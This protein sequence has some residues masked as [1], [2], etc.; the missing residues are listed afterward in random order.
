MDSETLLELGVQ[1]ADALDAAHGQ[2]IIHRDIK[3]ANIFV[4][5]HGQAKIVDF[6]LAKVIRRKAA[7]AAAG[8]SAGTAVSD[9]H[10]T[11]PGSALGTVAYMSPEQVLGKELDARTDLFSFGVVLYEMATGSQPFKGDTSGAISDAILHQAPVA[12][13]RLNNEVPAEL[14]RIIN[15]ALEKD[16]NLRYQHASEMRADLQRLKLDSDW[17]RVPWLGIFGA[18]ARLNW[19]RAALAA[20]GV[21]LAALLALGT[22]MAVLHLRAGAIDS[23]AVLPFVNTSADPSTDYL[24]DG[25]T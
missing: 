22:W 14:E 7:A 12:P 16:R 9:E 23:L 3:P 15:K 4:T 6:G 8:V 5:E 2:G 18:R 21:V 24:S 19:R 13:V 20:S 1:I 10:L 25:I 11:S 17:G